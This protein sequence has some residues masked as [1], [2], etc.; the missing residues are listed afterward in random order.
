MPQRTPY[1]QPMSGPRRGATPPSGQ[2]TVPSSNTSLTTAAPVTTNPQPTPP[3]TASTQAPVLP[4]S[5]A[6]IFPE[7]PS[8]GGGNTTYKPTTAPYGFDQ[9]MPGVNEQFWS[10]NQNMWFDTPGLDWVNGQ[11]PQ[12]ED[13]WA[14]EQA[15]AGSMGNQGS[16]Y[17][18]DY[19]EGVSG[20]MNS[21]SEQAVGKG[22]TDPN[23]ARL[24]F[25]RM[26]SALPGSLQPQFDAYYDRMKDKVMS[27][28]NSQ[29]AARGAYGS[30]TSLNNSIGA[31]LD[32]E[33]QRA[34]ASTDFMLDDSANQRDWLTAYGQQGR[35]ADLSGLGAYG[36]N[37]E[38]AK[39][40]LDKTKTLADIA[41]AADESELNRDKF[42]VD[43]ARTL[44]DLQRSRLDSGISTAFGLD[45]SY[46]GRLEGAFKASDTAQ[47]SRDDRVNTLYNQI[48]GFSGDVQSFLMD[49]YDA[50]LGGDMQMSDQELQTMIAQAADERGWDQQQQ[51]RIFR[52]AK[53]AMDI[54]TSKK[55]AGE[56]A[57]G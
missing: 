37:L 17:G 34:K 39:H 27:D 24:A 48:S 7:G 26:G 54:L 6:P 44:D 42:N 50:L 55:N 21:P 10:N 25:D 2:K 5:T 13:P 31:G 8:Y 30:N 11:L 19:W 38:G 3:P 4:P 49:N 12:F 1:Q 36:A 47:G 56:A 14:G 46:R 57:G 20:S 33:A 22:Y 18:A 53:A 9:S 41:F 32:M 16:R 40:G 23:L 28:V 52:D 35:A 45:D 51:E 29:S 15:I 43:R